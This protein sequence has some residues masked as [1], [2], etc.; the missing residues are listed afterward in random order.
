MTRKPFAIDVEPITG[1]P[2]L[3]PETSID[4]A[5][6]KRFRDKF[7]NDDPLVKRVERKRKKAK[8]KSK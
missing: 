1:G 7:G 3:D 5:A 2:I 4:K 6:L 8:G